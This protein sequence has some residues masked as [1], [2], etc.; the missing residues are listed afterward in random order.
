VRSRGDGSRGAVTPLMIALVFLMG[1]FVVV[2]GRLGVATVTQAQA[3]TAADAAA[4]AG[5]AEGR[6]AATAIAEANG[7]KLV[8]FQ[9]QGLDTRVTVALGRAHATARA[10]RGD[11]SVAEKVRGPGN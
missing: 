11:G 9:R 4:L 7:A 3:R 2:L 1:V 10:R 5:A 6:E 8:D